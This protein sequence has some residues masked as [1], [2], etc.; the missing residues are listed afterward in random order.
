V[1]PVTI[2]LGITVIRGLLSALD[3]PAESRTPEQLEAISAARK[4]A[5]ENLDSAIDDAI[6]GK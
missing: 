3:T 6:G 5:G 1:D 2:S 4:A